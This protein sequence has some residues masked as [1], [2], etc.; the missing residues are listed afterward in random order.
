MR[1]VTVVLLAVG[2]GLLL[3]GLG[4]LVLGMLVVMSLG[5]GEDSA[6]FADV[7]VQVVGTDARLQRLRFVSEQYELRVLSQPCD[8]I[9]YRDREATP[10]DPLVGPDDF[11]E[12][13]FVFDDGVFRAATNVTLEPARAYAL[14]VDRTDGLAVTLDGEPLVVHR[15]DRLENESLLEPSWL[16]LEAREDAPSE[17]R[18]RIATSWPVVVHVGIELRLQGDLDDGRARE[19]IVLVRPTGEELVL[20]DVDRREGSNYKLHAVQGAGEWTVRVEVSDVRTE[21]GRADVALHFGVVP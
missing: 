20:Q 1:M 13:R 8:S 12:L 6:Y 7:A 5:C 9:A 18:F 17:A 10:E 16:R 21:R 3:A 2:G 15:V 14:V 11:E 19:R 4:V